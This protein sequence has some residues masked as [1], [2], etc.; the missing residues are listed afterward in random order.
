[1]LLS[2]LLE[3]YTHV[4]FD[5]DI[6]RPTTDSK[7]ARRGDLFVA[8]RGEHHDGAEY[9]A[10]ALSNGARAVVT[11]SDIDGPRVVRV[12]DAGSA[13]SWIFS[14]YYGRPAEG[15]SVI[16]V[17]GTNGKTSTVGALSHIFGR[18]GRR[19]GTI[20]TVAL[21]A[22][23][24]EIDKEK[25]YGGSS[26]MTTPDADG[27]FRAIAAIRDAGCDT[28]V[29]EASSHALAAKR[30]DAL[31]PC[32]GVFTNLSPEHLDFHGDMESY[33]AAK[34]TLVS[35]SEKFVVNCDDAYG[36]RL[37]EKHPASYGVGTAGEN[38][39]AR[40]ENVSF[41]PRGVAY[42][43]VC[44]GKTS[45]I[46][47]PMIGSFA[48]YNT[49]CASAAAIL[50]GVSADA[51]ADALRDYGGAPGRMER[52][53]TGEGLPDV[54]IDYAHTPEALGK[55]IEAARTVA[56][57]RVIVVFGCGGERDRTKRAPMGRIASSLADVVI[58]TDD[59]PRGEDPEEIIADIM[60]GAYGDVKVVRGRETALWCAVETATEKDLILCCGKGHEKYIIDKRGKRPFDEKDILLEALR[61]K[62]G[63]SF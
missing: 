44:G 47:S 10:E 34:E 19:V 2:K 48:L 45:R 5:V 40:A 17:T 58:L 36:K 9:I 55:A 13:A 14:N 29:M 53:A 22:R 62:G 54:V 11:D 43:L 60:S 31:K 35:L 15:M 7:K 37:Y 25:F 32:V 41:S 23:G 26:T 38:I 24:E 63:R 4:P 61:C 1:M 51:A 50:T 28:L 18:A 57:G 30:L 3:G 27:L 59:N 56:R 42:D 16:A 49:L 52:I 6:W 20:G 39:F 8:L 12:N 46:E 33:F 21:T